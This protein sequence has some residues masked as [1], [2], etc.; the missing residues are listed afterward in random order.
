LVGVS[1]DVRENAIDFTPKDVYNFSLMYF[2]Q[3]K[4]FEM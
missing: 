3:A 2:L 4:L 1:V